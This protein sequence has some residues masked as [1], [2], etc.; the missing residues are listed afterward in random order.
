MD[1][2]IFSTIRKYCLKQLNKLKYRKIK[3]FELNADLVEDIGG[4]F[5]DSIKIGSI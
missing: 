2:I 1:F 5:V 4:F 3:M